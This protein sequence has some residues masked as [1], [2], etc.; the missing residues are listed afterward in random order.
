M[1]FAPQRRTLFQHL[2]LQQWS[3]P[4]VFWTFWLRNVLPATTACTVSTCQ[5]PS[6]VGD[7]QFLTRL[8]VWLQNV[9]RATTAC[10]FSTSGLPHVERRTL[11]RH[12]NFQKWSETDSLLHFWLGNIVV[13]VAVV[14]VIVVVVVVVV[15]IVVVLVVAV[16]VVLVVVVVV[17]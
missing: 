17:V 9:L 15:A 16:V 7:R 4:L 8:T 11:V 14:V 1:C 6:V 2:N 10:T 5:L 13:V 3:E 12:L